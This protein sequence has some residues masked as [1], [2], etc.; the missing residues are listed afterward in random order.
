[1]AAGG[2]FLRFSVSPA[3]T[4]MAA[5]DKPV[6]CGSVDFFPERLSFDEEPVLGGPKGAEVEGV[7]FFKPFMPAKFRR[8]SW[9][10]IYAFVLAQQYMA[11]SETKFF[12]KIVIFSFVFFENGWIIGRLFVSVYVLLT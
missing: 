8:R 5:C 1:M 2:N 7:D 3:S 12:F 10:L 11:V 9:L 4:L 6:C